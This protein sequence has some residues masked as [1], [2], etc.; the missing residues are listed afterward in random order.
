MFDGLFFLYIFLSLS[1]ISVLPLNPSPSFCHSSSSKVNKVNY[2]FTLYNYFP[3]CVIC[4]KPFNSLFLNALSKLCL[5]RA[6]CLRE[7]KKEKVFHHICWAFFNFCILFISI[8]LQYASIHILHCT[9]S[10]ACVVLCFFIGYRTWQVIV[11]TFRSVTN[12]DNSH[13]L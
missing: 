12:W 8:I 4:K 7:S 10:C 13:L 9:L 1:T 11:H 6:T 5:K 3:F 2:N